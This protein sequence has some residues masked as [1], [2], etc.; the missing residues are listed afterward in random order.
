MYTPSPEILRKYADVLI[1]FAL[2]GGKGI[3]KNEV[4]YI[5]SQQPG[6]PLAREIYRMVLDKGAYPLLNIM[7]DDF[8]LLHINNASK[9]Q[10]S[11]FPKKFYRGLANTI[12]HWVR[13]LADKE[14]LYLKDA[15]PKKI[16]LYQ[17]NTRPFRDW[18]DEKEDQ[19][20]FTWTLCLYGTPGLAAEAG[21]S[22]KAYWN[23]IIRACFLDEA[24]PISRWKTVYTQMNTI[25]K[26]LNRLPI[27]KIH[28]EAP[29]T[30]IWLTLGEKRR[31]L[32]G[33]GRN[34]PSFEIFTSPD[35]RGANGH[36]FF[37]LPLYRCGNIIKDITL[38]FKDGLIVK[39][40]AA[41]NEKLLHAMIKQRGADKIGEFSLTDRRFSRITRF[42]ADTLFDENFGGRYGNTHLA[43]GKSYHDTYSGDTT[44]MSKKQFDDLGFN[45][46]VEHTDIIASSNRTVTALLKNG[47]STVIYK[48]GEFQV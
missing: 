19:N 32:G 20:K 9:E 7:D 28:I 8:K 44:K 43:I 47:L 26:K 45:D 48:G 13:V 25:L 21:L 10:L 30:D 15:D 46:S 23:Q 6:L 36:I 1:N 38:E 11:F 2:N 39:A 16:L 22:D 35:W 14:P 4:V 18:L 24:D 33:R 12:D 27:D 29:R 42:M 34:I 40:T 41:Q 31:F 5:V 37:D 3:K 17:N